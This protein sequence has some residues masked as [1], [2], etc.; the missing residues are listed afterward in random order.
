MFGGM[1]FISQSIPYEIN[2]LSF[3]RVLIALYHPR[4]FFRADCHLQPAK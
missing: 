4:W 1:R 2:L 3:L